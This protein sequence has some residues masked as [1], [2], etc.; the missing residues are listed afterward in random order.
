MNNLLILCIMTMVIHNTVAVQRT[1]PSRTPK[2][3]LIHNLFSEGYDKDASPG[4][5]VTVNLTAAIMIIDLIELDI[6]QWTMKASGAFIIYWFDKRLSWNQTAYD[7]LR[8]IYL[9]C[10]KIWIPRTFPQLPCTK[11]RS[12]T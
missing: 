6:K 8:G 2:Q 10:E 9:P 1:S 3:Q 12:V 11:C 4:K 5:D 7:N